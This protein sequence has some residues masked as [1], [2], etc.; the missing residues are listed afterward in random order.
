[1]NFLLRWL[2]NAV[3]LALAVRLVPGLSTEGTGWTTLVAMAAVLGLVNAL[4]RPLV[5]LL[6]LPLTA[7]TFGLF[8]FVINA[9]MLWLAAWLTERLFPESK[10][11]IDGLIPALV[12]AL[13]VSIVSTV[14]SAL[15]IDDEK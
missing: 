12:G 10:F 6:T 14:L 4:I 9:G 1:M 7:V 5:R 2:I 15:L 8:S 3:A 13:V 11:V